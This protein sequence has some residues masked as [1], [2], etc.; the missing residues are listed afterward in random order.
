MEL[1]RPNIH[2]YVQFGTT[3]KEANSHDLIFILILI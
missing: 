3:L 1:L 2:G